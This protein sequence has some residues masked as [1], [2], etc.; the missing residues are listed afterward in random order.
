MMPKFYFLFLIFKALQRDYSELCDH[1]NN[2]EDR[3]TGKIVR[4]T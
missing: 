2:A 1:S 4:L 3:R